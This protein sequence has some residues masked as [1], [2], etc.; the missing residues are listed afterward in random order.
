MRK[1]PLADLA[2]RGFGNQRIQISNL[3]YRTAL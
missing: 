2:M 1:A 3:K